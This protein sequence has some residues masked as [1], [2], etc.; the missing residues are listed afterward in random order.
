M[1]DFSLG[2]VHIFAILCDSNYSLI[3][4]KK[5]IQTNCLKYYNND[6]EDNVYIDNYDSEFSW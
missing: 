4:I 1:S 3:E 6:P 2:F 5:G